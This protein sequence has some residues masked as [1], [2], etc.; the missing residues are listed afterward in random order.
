MSRNPSAAIGRQ[1]GVAHYLSAVAAANSFPTERLAI[2][3]SH[4]C[5][6]GRTKAF[7]AI[8]V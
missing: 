8:G 6:R 4:K 7:S 3:V 2:D 1:H 5:G